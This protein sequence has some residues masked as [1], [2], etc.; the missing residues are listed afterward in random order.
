VP[1]GECDRADPGGVHPRAVAAAQQLGPLGGG[2]EE[3]G[4]AALTPGWLDDPDTVQEA[5][6]HPEVFAGKSIGNHSKPMRTGEPG[7][8][9]EDEAP[10]SIR[11]RLAAWE[12]AALYGAAGPGH[13]VPGRT[14]PST[15]P[16]TPPSPPRRPGRS[17]L[18]RPHG[19]DDD[20]RRDGGVHGPHDGRR[21]GQEPPPPRQAAAMEPDEQVAGS[22]PCRCRRSHPSRAS[23]SRRV[24]GYSEGRRGMVRM[25]GSSPAQK[26]S[27]DSAHR[28]A[29][30][31][32]AM[33]ARQRG[34]TTPSTGM[35]R[36]AWAGYA[37]MPRHARVGRRS[38]QGGDR[39]RPCAVL[40]VG[41]RA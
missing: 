24:A 18:D 1:A 25:T 26:S 23:P 33:A 7:L 17:R 12:T 29:N 20:R 38:S 39:G 6:A 11:I 37:T 22:W 14:A 3:A 15:R 13:A 9:T 21:V 27:F 16:G 36:K 4:Y 19:Q 28:Q 35:A 30:T 8:D 10:G 40:P 31:Q 32:D 2:V 34:H 5:E 41:D